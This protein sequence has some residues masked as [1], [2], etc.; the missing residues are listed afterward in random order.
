M[1]SEGTSRKGA[2]STGC[3]SLPPL[4][5]FWDF[6]HVFFDITDYEDFVA[7][8]DLNIGDWFPD[9]TGNKQT[10]IMYSKRK[11]VWFNLEPPPS[12]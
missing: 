5:I 6:H 1:I 2:A 4:N 10:I 7:T 12:S 9:R 8:E 11:Q 3:L